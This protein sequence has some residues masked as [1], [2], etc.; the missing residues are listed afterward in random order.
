MKKILVTLALSCISISAFAQG[1]IVFA[2]RGGGV[3]APVTNIVDGT[4]I[5]GTAYLAQLYYG[6]AGATE[7]SLVPV[8]ATPGGATGSTVTFGTS[9]VAGYLVSGLG[10]AGN[11]YTDPAIA[12][13][14]A[15]T[16][17]QIRA[18]QAS[19]GSTWDAAFA[20][21]QSGPAGPVLGKS[22]IITTATSASSTSTPL[23]LA[24]MQGFYVTP[25][26]EPSVIALG[27]LGLAAILW[28]R[29]K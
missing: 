20:A 12:A 23:P 3:D 24:G 27:V 15:Q 8:L 19:L 6:A 28:R 7:G 1:G 26:P 2:T 25:V 10:G 14:G 21:W 16:A 4:R 11:R 5:A 9:T 18:W 22:A 17:F 13:P 29:R